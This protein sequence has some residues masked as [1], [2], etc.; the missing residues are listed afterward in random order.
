[1]WTRSDILLA[2]FLEPFA[3]MSAHTLLNQS[4]SSDLFEKSF[5]S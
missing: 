4:D 3:R 1:M 2:A 5:S